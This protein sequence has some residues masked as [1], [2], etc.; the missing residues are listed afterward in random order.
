MNEI[1]IQ[2]VA[3]KFLDLD[4]NPETQALK[5]SLN[6]PLV[7]YK[8]RTQITGDQ[9]T[10]AMNEDGSWQTELVDTDN[11][12]GEIWYIFEINDKIY[13]KLVPVSAHCHNFNDLPDMIF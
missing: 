2:R 13:R 7:L 1:E 6:R 5:I 9:Q 8:N 10:V 12:T 11:M 4:I 3:G